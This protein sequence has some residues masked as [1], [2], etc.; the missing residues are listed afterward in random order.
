MDELTKLRSELEMALSV[1][2]QHGVVLQ[3]QQKRIEQL[4]REA[5]ERRHD[6]PIKR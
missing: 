4:E 1:V 2:R 5:K 6:G 3:D